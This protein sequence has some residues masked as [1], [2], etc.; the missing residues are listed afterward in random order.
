MHNHFEKRTDPALLVEGAKSIIV[1]ALNYYPSRMKDP[2]LPAFSYY[3]YG[4]DYHDVMKAKLRQLYAF[5]RE[6]TGREPAGRAFTDS[7]PVLERYWAVQAGLGFIGKNTQLII[8]GKGSYFFL[9]ELILDLELPPD[10]PVKGGCGSCTRCLDQC[11]PGALKRAGRLDSRLCISY[12]TI[13]NRGEIDQRVRVSLGNRV[14]GCDVCQQVCPWNR[15]AR[16]NR[17]E[18][19]TASD[20]FLALDRERMEA[21]TE[22]D[23][24]RIFRGSAVKRAGYNGLKRNL[25]ALGE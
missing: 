5:V 20:E 10:S 8:P 18:E 23:F 17:T 3:A 21:M 7:A 2:S 24:R 15:F 19:F 22:D 6:T 11:P 13:E 4:K 12:Q 9:G 25:N 16:P 14:Y 1:V